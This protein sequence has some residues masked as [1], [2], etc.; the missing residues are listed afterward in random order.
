MEF[1]RGRRRGRARVKSGGASEKY[2]AV[3]D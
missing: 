2:V 1:E 3:L